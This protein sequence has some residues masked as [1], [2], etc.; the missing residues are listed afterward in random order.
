MDEQVRYGYRSMMG[1]LFKW[2]RYSHSDN[3][4]QKQGLN[5]FRKTG[6]NF[7]TP[8]F[9]IARFFEEVRSFLLYKTIQIFVNSWSNVKLVTER[10]AKTERP[11]GRT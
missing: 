7:L 10:E 3:K 6:E 1:R 8:A 2:K 5:I 9:G 11:H 4:L